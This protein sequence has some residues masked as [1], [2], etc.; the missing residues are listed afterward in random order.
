MTAQRAAPLKVSPQ[1]LRL[2]KG[3]L[4]TTFRMGRGR[5]VGRLI[6]VDLNSLLRGLGNYFKLFKLKPGQKVL[7]P[8]F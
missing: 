4:K 5:N 7:A 6:E 1:A 2:L 8:S 3:K